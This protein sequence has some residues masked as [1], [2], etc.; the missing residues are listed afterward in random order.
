MKTNQ[1]KPAVL[2]FSTACFLASCA[3]P[4]KP[5]FTDTPTAGSIAIVSDES[6]Q[7][8]IATEADTFS[9]LYR[10]AKLSVR[11]RPEALAF[12]EF[13]DNDTVRLII[14]ARE[15]NEEENL[16][17]K[18]R[19]IYPRTTKVAIDAVA[20]VLNNDNTDSSI[21]YEQLSGI[22][23]GKIYS[24]KQLN[25]QSPDDSIHIVFD[26]NGS[27]NTRYLKEKF[28]GKNPFPA[29]CYATNSNADVIE[30][31]SKNK[32]ALGIISLNWISDLDDPVSNGFLKKIRVAAISPPDT[33]KL[34]GTFFK[35]YQGYLALNQYPLTR[36][37]Y[38]ISR[39]GRN[40]LGTGFAAFVA[41]D[42][43]QRIVRLMG[44]LPATMPVR[45]VRINQ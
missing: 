24:W 21:T 18:G 6:Y 43:G 17:F 13:T 40:G 29:N 26:R 36:S 37:I 39:E 9:G 2:L 25:R 28:L 33:S 19:N 7:P 27:A 15:L 44:M 41:G 16:F 30:Y 4:G 3:E 35:P 20:I 31:V 14:S 23:N 34:A 12:R 5:K 42:Q 38:I 11:Y 45:L 8:L 32:Q 10:Q 22:I 1:L